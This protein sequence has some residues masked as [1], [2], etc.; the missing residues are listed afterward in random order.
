M[1]TF[2][3]PND[4]RSIPSIYVTSGHHITP[5][6][7]ALV[8][9][10]LNIHAQLNAETQMNFQLERQMKLRVEDATTSAKVLTYK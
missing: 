2:S 5:D 3:S 1:G 9:I 8:E 10:Y 4:R 7:K 6:A